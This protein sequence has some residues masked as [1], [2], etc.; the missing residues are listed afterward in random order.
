MKKLLSIAV[1]LILALTLLCAGAMAEAA[2]LTGEW[3]GSLYGIVMTLTLNEDG[4]YT[5]AMDSEDPESGVWELDGSDLILDR[6]T[7]DEVT[8]AY[9]ADEVSLAMDLDGMAFL[10]TREPVAAFELA[11]ARADATLEE[12]AGSWDCTLVSMMGMQLP[13]EEAEIEMSLVIEGESAQLTLGIFGEPETIDLVPAFADGALTLTI[14]ASYEGEEDSVI[15]FQ[16]LEDGTMS[17][18]TLL[19]DEE[20]IFVLEAA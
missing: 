7:D 4:S 5:L 17:A 1:S 2:E 3:Y 9:D 14:P 13:P 15:T 10:F 8:F 16:L 20:L 18:T 6:G 19:F 11:A 12:Y